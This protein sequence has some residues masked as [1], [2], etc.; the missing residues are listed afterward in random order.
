MLKASIKTSTLLI[1]LLLSCFGKNGYCQPTISKLSG[2]VFSGEAMTIT[3]ANFGENGPSVAVYDDFEGGTLGQTVKTGTG[4][5]TA[6][7]WDGYDGGLKVAYSNV[8]KYGGTQSLEILNTTITGGIRTKLP[9]NNLEVFYTFWA[10]VP[11][12]KWWPG[13]ISDTDWSP[14]NWKI[15][16]LKNDNNS[17]STGADMYVPAYLGH[18]GPPAY[19]T[20][21]VSGNTL[22]SSTSY[23]VNGRPNIKRGEWFRLSAWIKGRTDGTGQVHLWE[24]TSEGMQQRININNANTIRTGGPYYYNTFV[25]NGFARAGAN[26]A[27]YF[28]DAYVATGI[29]A[30]ARIEIGDNPAYDKCKVLS[31]F[32]PT[33]WSDSVVTGKVNLSRFANETKAYLFVFDSN[34]VSNAE[35]FPVKI[36]GK[37]PAPPTPQN[38]IHVK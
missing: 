8:S 9:S 13:A 19:L 34:G 17:T 15:V 36:G 16:W 3:G 4:S 37:Y 22:G 24:L 29:N 23:S 18:K 33:S 11:T 38:V 6:G 12:D 1:L 2:T 14:A 26:N 21:L 25:L 10:Y 30:R 7:Q 27:I 32:V 35:G 31:M 20:A 5:A 28:D